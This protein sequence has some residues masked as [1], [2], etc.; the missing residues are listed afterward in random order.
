MR[1]RCRVALLSLLGGR[2]GAI[3]RLHASAGRRH[4]WLCARNGGDAATLVHSCAAWL[5]GGRGGDA[6][7]RGA[8]RMARA[9]R[10]R[11]DRKSVVSGKN[12][13][14]RVDLGGRRLIKKKKMYIE[15]DK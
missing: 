1:R 3:D 5:V 8:D 11:R 7:L 2:R 9:V 10:R 13:S 14:V 4:R 6:D 12:V 15:N